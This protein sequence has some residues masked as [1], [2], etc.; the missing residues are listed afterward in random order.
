MKNARCEKVKKVKIDSN[1]QLNLSK[2]LVAL[3]LLLNYKRHLHW[4]VWNSQWIRFCVWINQV[5]IK[6]YKPPHYTA[7]FDR[8]G[9]SM[10]IYVSFSWPSP[11]LT[12][13]VFHSPNPIATE[14]TRNIL[15]D[16]MCRPSKS[17]LETKPN[18]M[19]CMKC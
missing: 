5:Y 16:V 7:H 13:I 14:K 2:T 8:F 15:M 3:S 6:R 9:I 1:F 18:T 17:Y 19:P 4:T 11:A 12:S 10:S